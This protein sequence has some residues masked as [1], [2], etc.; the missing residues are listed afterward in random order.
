M[1]DDKATAE[2][3]S[4]SPDADLTKKNKS[5]KWWK[6]YAAMAILG[7][8]NNLAYVVVNSSAQ[9]LS[10]SYPQP[11]VSNMLGAIPFCNIV[12]AFAVKF[13]NAFYLENIPHRWRLTANT[14]CM[15]I[16]LYFLAVSTQL[17]FAV[18]LACIIVV[19]ATSGFGESVI[20]GMLKFYDSELV[21]GWSA[22]TGVAG[23]AGSGMYLICDIIGLKLIYT[24]LLLVPS[25][26]IYFY[27]YEFMLTPPEE[28]AASKQLAATDHE[29]EQHD[30][31]TERESVG[32]LDS[33]STALLQSDDHERDLVS[34]HAPSSS[35]SFD[36]VDPSIQI[37]PTIDQDEG[38]KQTWRC[39]KVSFWL[40][41]NL[42]L[43]YFFEYVASTGAADKSNPI[44]SPS[45]PVSH[46]YAI[47]S[48]CYQVGVLISRS[49]L[50]WVHIR[51]V[52]VLTVLQ[53]VNFLLWMFQASFHFI[54]I[55]VQFVLMVY[56]G[57]LG[58]A[59]YVNIFY[60]FLHDDNFLER[61]RELCINLATIWITAGITLASL[62]TI[63]MDNTWLKEVST[64]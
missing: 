64:F 33:D 27:A 52:E 31:S 51:R 2:T 45:W 36:A 17:N 22:G 10:N 18:A 8:I 1:D 62:F 14:V 19:G 30:R 43:V 63:L 13:L 16:G 26:F 11:W 9:A 25:A 50:Q 61:D 7:T 34:S 32:A 4:G 23:V 53:L 49:S 60:R 56:V 54:N 39:L 42:F 6:D 58:G 59:S 12:A 29:H 41:L 48:F 15:L 46:G 57:L 35:L 24:Y 55:W 47:L 21:G 3:T 20:L 28:A 40:S 37:E 44:D 38:W 5:T